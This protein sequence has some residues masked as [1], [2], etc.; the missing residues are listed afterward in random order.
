MP[1]PK[2]KMKWCR[3]ST[4]WKRSLRKRQENID[5]LSSKWQS[6][7]PVYMISARYI[8]LNLSVVFTV[9][10]CIYYIYSAH[11]SAIH[12]TIWSTFNWCGLLFSKETGSYCTRW[13]PSHPRT[14]RRT[15]FPTTSSST[16]RRNDATSSTTSTL[17]C[18]DA[19]PTTSS[20][21]WRPSTSPW[22]PCSWWPTA[23]S[24]SPCRP[25]SQEEE[26][27]PAVKSTEV[28][29]LVQVVWGEAT[30]VIWTVSNILQPGT[31]LIIK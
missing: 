18:H 2:R 27:S 17:W 26:Y 23:S 22:T 15:S 4:R 30:W 8:E 16:P 21:T 25:S 19:A 29:Q 13:S 6:L 3:P 5:W 7:V 20:S 1:N 31:P 24:R 11:N 10:Y 12:F 9:L 14:P 28:L